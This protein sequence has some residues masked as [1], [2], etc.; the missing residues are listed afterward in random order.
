[1]LLL[2]N[3]SRHVFKV[4]TCIFKLLVIALRKILCAVGRM[5]GNPQSTPPFLEEEWSQD[6]QIRVMEKECVVKEG[7]K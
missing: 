1:M 2:E 5:R 3:R 7:R 4:Y 6:G